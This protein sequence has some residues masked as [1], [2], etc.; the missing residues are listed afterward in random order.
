MAFAAL[1]SFNERVTR[2][3]ELLDTVPNPPA[4]MEQLLYAASAIP[5]IIFSTQLLGYLGD[6]PLS[7]WDAI[8]HLRTGEDI[9]LPETSEKIESI[10]GVTIDVKTFCVGLIKCIMQCPDDIKRELFEHLMFFKLLK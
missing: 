8:D 5:S 7:V 4:E 10:M 9:T 2:F 1:S 6:I 3:M